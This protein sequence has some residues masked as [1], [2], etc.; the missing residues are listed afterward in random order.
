MPISGVTPAPLNGLPPEIRWVDPKLL[1][2]EPEY[3]RNI[4]EGS[5]AL[6]RK[7]VKTWDWS[8]FKPPVCG[9]EGGKLF[10]VD[11]QH[12]AIAAASHGGI[13]KIPVVV[14]ANLSL[15]QRAQAFIGHNRDRLNVT[16]MQMHFAALASGDEIAVALQQAAD[17]AKVNILRYPPQG[18][19]FKPRDLVCIGTASKL[20]KARGVNGCAR[21]LSLLAEAKRAPITAHE[22]RATANL[23]WGSD[24][25]IDEHHLVTVIRSREVREW[26]A[27]AEMERSRSKIPVSLD[28][29]LARLWLAEMSL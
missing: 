20:V 22:L 27:D 15:Q 28:K 25:R 18:G 24:K 4:S 19:F 13:D 17:K 29:V 6:I 9:Q 11:G 26:K 3:Q 12:T 8:R 5:V 14:I 1:H 10:V 21:A 2:V 23:L 16:V 7:I